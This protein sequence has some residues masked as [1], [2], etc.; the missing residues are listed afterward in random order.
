[1]FP[2]SSWK[3]RSIALKSTPKIVMRKKKFGGLRKLRPFQQQRPI[4]TF[5]TDS[6][7]SPDSPRFIQSH[8]IRR[9]MFPKR[10][11]RFGRS[12]YRRKRLDTVCV[13]L[14]AC[15][16]FW[17]HLSNACHCES[18][19]SYFIRKIPYIYLMVA[20]IYASKSWHNWNA[21]REATKIALAMCITLLR[22]QKPHR[23]CTR[24]HQVLGARTSQA[25]ST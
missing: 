8:Y 15:A 16:W 24:Q 4:Y 6:S 7:V 21:W 20:F 9:Q 23:P 11:R 18:C 12:K 19:A 25:I 17:R 5:Y 2:S 22:T 10:Q 1:M 3:D 14:F 13:V